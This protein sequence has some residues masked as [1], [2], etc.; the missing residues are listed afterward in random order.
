MSNT[1]IFLLLFLDIIM[2]WERTLI[3]CLSKLVVQGKLILNNIGYRI[4]KYGEGD[5]SVIGRLEDNFN[6]WK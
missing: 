6:S 4:Y 3:K 2:L 1:T 5:D